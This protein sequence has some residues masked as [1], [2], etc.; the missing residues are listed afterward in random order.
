MTIDQLSLEQLQSFIT[1]PT[2]EGGLGLLPAHFDAAYS[3]TDAIYGI[4]KFSTGNLFFGNIVGALGETSTVACLL[5]AGLLLLTGIASWR[6]MLSFGLS[7][8]FFAWLFKIISV[9]TA[10]QAGAWAP[11]KFFIPVYRHLFIG[12]LA[13]GLVFMATDPFLLLQPN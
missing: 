5:G 8:L 10:G 12:G 7:S 11:A 13:F 3:L 9:L 6:T 1:A 2:A 4:G